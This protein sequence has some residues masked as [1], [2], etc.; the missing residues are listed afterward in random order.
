[1]T[2]PI[3]EPTPDTPEP[4]VEL[5]DD[6]A[7]RDMAAVRRLRAENNDYGTSFAKSRKTAAPLR[8]RDSP[9]NGARR[10]N[11]SPAR[12][13]SI[14]RTCG[15]VDAAAQQAFVDDEFGEIV[16]DRVVESAEALAASKPHLA[17]PPRDRHPQTDPSKV[18]APAPRLTRACG[19]RRPGPP[20]CAAP[21]DSGSTRCTR[22]GD[23]FRPG[24]ASTP[25]AG[26]T[27]AA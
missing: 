25:L 27:R 11:A 7:P 4:D 26:L 1:M 20:H 16:A 8:P 21:K 24:A 19:R 14:P 6:E 23:V 2:E 12:C 3:D 15:G 13:W 10:P 22:P 9:R 17:R 5:G 18:C